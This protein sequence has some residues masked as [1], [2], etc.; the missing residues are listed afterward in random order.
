ME[1]VPPPFREALVNVS[2]EV[3]AVPGKEAGRRKNLLGLCLT[4]PE[5]FPARI[6][7][8]Q[9]PIESICA[10]EAEL[11]VEI[12]RTLKH[13]IA[14]YLGMSERDIHRAWPEGA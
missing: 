6:L 5:P 13:E 9:R 7:L 1:R 14:H 10:D 3:K 8:Y 12:E 11:K 2:I 4:Q